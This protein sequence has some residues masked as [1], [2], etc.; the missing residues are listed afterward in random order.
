M[1]MS[2]QSRYVLGLAL[3]V[4]VYL[5]DVAK[6]PEV[7]RVKIRSFNGLC[8]LKLGSKQLLQNKRI[9]PNITYSDS[10]NNLPVLTLSCKTTD[11]WTLLTK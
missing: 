4:L 6:Q 9:A 10:V 3:P 11:V 2:D 7:D 8:S 1:L 5:V